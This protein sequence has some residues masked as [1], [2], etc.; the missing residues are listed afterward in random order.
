MNK[1]LIFGVIVVI[2][3]V[4]AILA[5]AGLN[6]QI[7]PACAKEKLE[8]IGSGAVSCNAVDDCERSLDNMGAPD[9]LIGSLRL[10]CEGGTCYGIPQ[11]CGV[12]YV[13][14]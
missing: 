10:S 2:A 13:Q 3:I 8:L 5:F 1:P 12:K 11:E 9:E 7:G 4:A 14:K 6:Y